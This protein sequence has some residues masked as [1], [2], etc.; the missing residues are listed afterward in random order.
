MS[1][2]Q[3]DQQNNLK[4]RVALQQYANGQPVT[5]V[6]LGDVRYHGRRNRED[7]LGAEC[8]STNARFSASEWDFPFAVTESNGIVA[9]IKKALRRL[10]GR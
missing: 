3:R 10:C 5:T 8:C 4:Q 7:E 2:E 6:C 1:N 9:L